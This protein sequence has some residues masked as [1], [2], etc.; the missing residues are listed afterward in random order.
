MLQ[1][2]SDDFCSRSED[3]KVQEDDEHC[4]E[5]AAPHQVLRL[6]PFSKSRSL[7]FLPVPPQRLLV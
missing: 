6:Q 1:V 4:R 2:V 7:L 3:H 5:V